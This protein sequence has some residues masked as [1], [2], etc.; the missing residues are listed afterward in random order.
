MI[1][2]V[3]L[4]SAQTGVTLQQS[5]LVGPVPTGCNAFVGRASASTFRGAAPDSDQVELYLAP[6][7]R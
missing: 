2:P 4:V 7:L 5:T 3:R 1:Q 6:L